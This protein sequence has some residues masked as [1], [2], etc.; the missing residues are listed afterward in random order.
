M[1]TAEAYAE[2]EERYLAAVRGF[3]A[4][5]GVSAVR[6]ASLEIEPESTW[7]GRVG[8]GDELA[9]DDAVELARSMLREEFVWCL[10]SGPDG[11]FAHF[12]YDYYMYLGGPGPAEEAV[13]AA[14]RSGL[15]VD[16]FTSPYWD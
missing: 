1:L 9:I 7:W 2:T 6:V 10:L 11:F 5:Y 8:E 13:G 3:A 14:R 4:A 16:G 15:Q 12:G